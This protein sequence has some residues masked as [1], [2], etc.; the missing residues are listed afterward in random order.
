MA[1][2]LI[3]AGRYRCLTCL[4]LIISHYLAQQCSVT[5]YYMSEWRKGKGTEEEKAGK[6]AGGRMRVEP[7]FSGS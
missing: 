4:L 5:I 3:R 6:K 1:V 2:S 7:R